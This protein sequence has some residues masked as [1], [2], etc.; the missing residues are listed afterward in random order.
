[1]DDEEELQ[2][3]LESTSELGESNTSIRNDPF[4]RETCPECLAPVG[5]EC[6]DP[7][8]LAGQALGMYHCPGCGV[9]QVA[10]MAHI[11]CDFCQGSGWV[12]R[13]LMTEQ[14]FLG[15]RDDGR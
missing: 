14:D 4:F 12:R 15:E 11:D 7:R 9:M 2:E 6:D 3:K 10:G 1:M 5:E 13:T 8:T